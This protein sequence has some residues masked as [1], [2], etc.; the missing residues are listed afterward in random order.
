[1]NLIEVKG[2]AFLFEISKREKRL[3]FELLKFYPLV[4]PDHYEFPQSQENPSIESAG[5]LLNETLVEEKRQ[6]RA[7]LEAL[8][9]R[10][11]KFIEQ[12]NQVRMELET[13]EIEWLLQILNEIRVGS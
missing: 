7:E 5:K 9:K 10:G 13:M 1:M 12:A 4:P 6:K 2:E 3:L 11:D 8:L